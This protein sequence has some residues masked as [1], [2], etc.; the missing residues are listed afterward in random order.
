MPKRIFSFW[1]DDRSLTVF[2]ILLFI[3]MFVVT[4]EARHSGILGMI[5]SIGLALILT[6][7][8]FAM[9]HNTALRVTI[10]S[11]IAFF[12]TVHWVRFGLE[13]IVLTFIERSL[14]ILF[15]S[16]MLAVVL[17]QVYKRG[18]VTGHR[19]RGAVA[20]YLLLVIIFSVAYSLIDFVNPDSFKYAVSPEN[21][22]PYFVRDFLYFSVVTLTTLGYGDIVPVNPVART[23]A[24]VEALT[25][26]L[27]LAILIARLVSSAVDV[28]R[29]GPGA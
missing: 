27:Y 2:L 9:T 14:T 23:I 6:G 28:K 4:P 20:G 19:I 1:S 15:A 13:G 11:L 26:Q 22:H 12:L 17:W 8:L 18:P 25:G 16:A 24:M 5:S 10:A 7:G 3:Y 21:A 29:A